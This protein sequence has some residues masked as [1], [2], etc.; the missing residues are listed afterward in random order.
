MLSFTSFSSHLGFL[1]AKS[2]Q[3]DCAPSHLVPTKQRTCQCLTVA[4]AGSGQCSMGSRVKMG[5]TDGCGSCRTV[6]H[7]GLHIGTF[8]LGLKNNE[9]ARES[10]QTDESVDAQTDVAPMLYHHTG[11]R[12]KGVTPS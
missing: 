4:A 8:F 5:F 1:L 9:G 3:V 10:L 2:P 12:G 11:G 7:R 6:E